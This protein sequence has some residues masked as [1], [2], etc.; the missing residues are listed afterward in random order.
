M[1]MHTGIMSGGSGTRLWPLSRSKFPKQFHPLVGDETMVQQTASR[2]KGLKD[3]GG[4]IVV[5]NEDHRFLVAEQLKHLDD[6][7]IILEPCARNTAPAVALAAFELQEQDPQSLMLVLSADHVILN[8]VAFRA[9]V[10]EARESAQEG[11]IITFGIVPT[12][13]ATG[14]GYIKVGKEQ[15][16]DI[17]KVDRFVE[18]PQESVAKAY[19]S[20]GQYLW[21]SGV[22]IIRSDVY[23]RELK[24]SE[25]EVYEACE[26]AMRTAQKDPDFI[27]PNKVEFES[28]PKISIDYAVMEKSKFVNVTPLDADWS[29]V[30]SWSE[31]A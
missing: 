18:K 29:D 20:S 31:L 21:N 12:Y 11:N 27:R 13:P 3:L 25:P 4:T 5:A 28:C 14:Y 23:L 19:L 22:F 7:S 15:S 10:E 1:S 26:K 30:G 24:N 2:L 9:S 17:F 8:Q 6:L 16:H